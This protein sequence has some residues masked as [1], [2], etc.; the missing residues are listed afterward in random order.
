MYAKIR[1]LDTQS[2]THTIKDNS[3]TRRK[4]IKYEGYIDPPPPPSGCVTTNCEYIDPYDPSRS[5]CVPA[6][7]GYGYVDNNELC[8]VG[9][10][11]PCH[12]IGNGNHYCSKTCIQ[13]CCPGNKKHPSP[14]S[15]TNDNSCD[16]IQCE[17]D[18]GSSKFK[19]NCIPAVYGKGTHPNICYVGDEDPCY[20][21]NSGEDY[22]PKS[23]VSRCCPGNK[24]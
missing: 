16:L 8:F 5:N 21:V 7:S 23:C 12:I 4:S 15:S 19:V 10:N 11:D 20:L 2:H 17:Y 24:K 22:C 9:I 1:T 13:T 18:D 3:M 6:I 14:T